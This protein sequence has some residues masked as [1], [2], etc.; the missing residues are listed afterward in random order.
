MSQWLSTVMPGGADTRRHRGKRRRL[1]RHV[2]GD[3]H[4]DRA[5]GAG[6]P[7]GRAE[8]G[9]AGGAHRRGRPGVPDVSAG[10]PV[11]R[12]PDG[13]RADRRAGP[14]GA[15][16]GEHRRGAR[17]AV[18]P[19]GLRRRRGAARRHALHVRRQLVRRRARRA[20]ARAAGRHRRGAGQAA[21][22]PGR[23][24]DVR[25]PRPRVSRATPRCAGTSTGSRSWYE[26]A[27]PD[28][29]RSPLLERTFALA[30]GQLAE[31]RGRRR[32][33]AALGRCPGRQRA[34][35]RLPAGRGAGLGDGDARARASSTS[36]G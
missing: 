17:H 1:Q 34:L 16:A 29:G 27:V 32:A 28:I 21:L 10:P 31:R 3:H 14:P 4:P 13:R 6:R 18:L 11:R 24:E 8:V 20:S 36:P 35:P 15:L 26:F 25:L 30:G 33:G 12:H 5:L 22:D 2:V 19:D 23:G 9:G 7:A